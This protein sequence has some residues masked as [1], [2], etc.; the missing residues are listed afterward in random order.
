M[1]EAD[2]LYDPL[3]YARGMM[4]DQSDDASDKCGRMVRG[5]PPLFRL[6]AREGIYWIPYHG[7]VGLDE[8][9]GRFVIHFRA[10]LGWP[11]DGEQRA[12]EGCWKATVAGLRLDVILNHIGMGQRVALNEG[13]TPSDTTGPCVQTI[14]LEPVEPVLF[15]ELAERP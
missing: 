2:D 3:A 6:V 11:V 14:T 9:K 4:R 10:T 15:E 13:G 1:D 8:F 7:I 12:M 5:H